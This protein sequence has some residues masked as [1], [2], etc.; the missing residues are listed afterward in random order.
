MGGSWRWALIS[1]DGVAPSQMVC[2]SASVNLPWH[3]PKVCSGTGS[4]EWFQKK[5]RKTVVVC[6][7]VPMVISWSV[8]NFIII[9]IFDEWLSITAH[10]TDKLLHIHC[11]WFC[12][13]SP[14]LLQISSLL[15]E[16][17]PWNLYSTC[18]I[19]YCNLPNWQLQSTETE[20]KTFVTNTWSLQ[21]LSY[22]VCQQRVSCWC[23]RKGH[24]PFGQKLLWR[25]RRKL[26]LQAT[27]QSELCNQ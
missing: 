9:G 1:P 18:Q 23:C 4:S 16:A 6:A 21:P 22:S 15:P 3:F 2:V 13:H 11:F 8:T 14:E 5:G 20:M 10:A 7:V 19:P 17:S 12:P 27:N 25:C 26:I 24:V